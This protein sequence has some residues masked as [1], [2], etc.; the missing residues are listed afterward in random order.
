MDNR[1]TKRYDWKY[2]DD[3]ITEAN[4]DQREKLDLI[5]Q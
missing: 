2:W 1:K 3:L 4:G 5:G